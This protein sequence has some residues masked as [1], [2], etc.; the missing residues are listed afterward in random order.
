MKLL[1]SLEYVPKDAEYICEYSGTN[2]ET[3]YTYYWHNG[4]IY[5]VGDW[6]ENSP[7]EITLNKIVGWLMETVNKFV[8]KEE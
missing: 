7:S 3:I 6:T 5:I 8:K 2:K 1:N 4:E